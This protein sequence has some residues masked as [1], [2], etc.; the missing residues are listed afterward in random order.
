MGDAVNAMVD[1][2][3]MQHRWAIYK[4]QGIS[5]TWRFLNARYEDALSDARDEL[6]KKLCNNVATW[7]NWNESAHLLP[8]ACWVCIQGSKGASRCKLC[9]HNTDTSD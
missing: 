6:E 5:S 9:W 1:S 8:T 3:A 4:S 7:E 2:L